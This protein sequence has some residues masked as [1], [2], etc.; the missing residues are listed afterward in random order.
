MANLGKEPGGT[1]ASP[2]GS[3]NSLPR[4]DLV[5]MDVLVNTDERLRFTP[6]LTR[7][8][9]EEAHT[10]AGWKQGDCG[11]K[12][13]RGFS[14]AFKGVR[15]PQAWHLEPMRCDSLS[16]KKAQLR[17][18]LPY[19]LASKPLLRNSSLNFCFLYFT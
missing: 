4:W 7:G 15:S 1:C 2:E 16:S 8:Q 9:T 13:S 10:R 14:D 19:N 18:G 5:H 12:S 11:R 6:G 17:S 3:A